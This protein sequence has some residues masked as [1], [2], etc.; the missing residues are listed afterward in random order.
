MEGR[1]PLQD[2]ADHLLASSS[3]PALPEPQELCW[4]TDFPQLPS[5]YG[6]GDAA[7]SSSLGGA[8]GNG[9][10]EEISTGKE[11]KR[12]VGGGGYRMR[13]AAKPR[14]AF[15]TRS[16]E[17]VLDDGYRWRKYGQKAVKNSVYPRYIYIYMQTEKE[18]NRSDRE[19]FDQMPCLLQSTTIPTIH[20]LRLP[21]LN[22]D[23]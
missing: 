1:E 23:I 14:F 19:P 2:L 4:A 8:P 18:K 10:D 16:S 7:G 22:S 11:K 3:H 12:K 9:K 17:D 6:V 15:R 21:E 13:N 5:Q 20:L